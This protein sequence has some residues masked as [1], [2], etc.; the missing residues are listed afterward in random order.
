MS[1]SDSRNVNLYI[2]PLV[3][4]FLSVSMSV[5]FSQVSVSNIIYENQIDIGC[6]LTV[7]AVITSYFFVFYLISKIP[8]LQTIP[9]FLYIIV[10]VS[11]I[12][13]L[14]IGM[15]DIRGT[16]I[17]ILLSLLIIFLFVTFKGIETKEKQ[18][19]NKEISIQNLY[20]FISLCVIVISFAW[21][22]ANS[23]ELLVENENIWLE[24][25]KYDENG[26][27]HATLVLQIKALKYDANN[28][29]IR[30]IC[31]DQIALDE[32]ECALLGIDI[33]KK[34]EKKIVKWNIMFEDSSTHS[35]FLYL[36]HSSEISNKR[37]T[38]H[39]KDS[40]RRV[41]IEDVGYMENFLI[42]LRNNPILSEC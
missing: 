13:I 9:E 20:F 10:F 23:S 37:I 42:F 18:K 3:T 6:L 16:F 27:I 36:V 19:E 15:S 4:V 32:D 29:R 33:L 30:I 7:I 25:V 39:S 22:F 11:S 8:L 38:I 28:I 5:F 24:N 14:L 34:G 1:D 2:L 26:L 21:S 31:Q 17:K 40:Q 35:F 12:F 41:D